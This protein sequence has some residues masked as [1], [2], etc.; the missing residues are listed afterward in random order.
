MIRQVSCWWFVTQYY[1]FSLSLAGG[2]AYLC[3]RNPANIQQLVTVMWSSE[4]RSSE[5]APQQQVNVVFTCFP[6]RPAWHSYAYFP[7]TG[8][9]L[10]QL[11]LCVY[12]Y[13]FSVC[14]WVHV[15]VCKFS[16]HTTTQQF[17]HSLL[18]SPNSQCL[19]S[20]DTRGWIHRGDFF[21]YWGC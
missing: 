9:T 4:T 2:P 16:S 6:L 1:F 5:T 20:E 11:T 17:V 8:L 7:A 10:G 13:V 19:N 3:Q 12:I 21:Y 14:G 18:S 15:C